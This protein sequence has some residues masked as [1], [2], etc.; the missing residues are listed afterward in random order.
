MRYAVPWFALLYA[1]GALLVLESAPALGAAL[2]ALPV[3]LLAASAVGAV[4]PRARLR[5]P[6]SAA[7]YFVQVNVAVMLAGIQFLR[8]KRVRTWVPTRR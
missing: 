3:L 4:W 2:L 6:I 7:Y 8:G 1:A 5:S